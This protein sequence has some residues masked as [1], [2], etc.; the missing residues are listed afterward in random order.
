MMMIHRL[1]QADLVSSFHKRQT[2]RLYKTHRIKVGDKIQHWADPRGG[3]GKFLMEAVCLE[4]H[5]VQFGME[6]VGNKVWSK[7]RPIVI[8][9]GREATPQER[10][11]MAQADGYSGPGEMINHFA[12]KYF[13]RSPRGL[14]D[15]FWIKW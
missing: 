12:K 4:V 2:V 14:F 1:D 15:V 3:K 5:R 13:P 10:V 6:K 11:E 7:G 9:D 8:I